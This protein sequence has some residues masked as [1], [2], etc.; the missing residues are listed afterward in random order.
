[1]RVVNHITNAT[2]E[3]FQRLRGA[4]KVLDDAKLQGCTSFTLQLI[5]TVKKK[6]SR[7]ATC[8]T[9]IK[10]THSEDLRRLETQYVASSDNWNNADSLLEVDFFFFFFL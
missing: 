7:S 2:C 4:N 1:M 10:D 9:S 3:S 6:A 8:Q 5:Q